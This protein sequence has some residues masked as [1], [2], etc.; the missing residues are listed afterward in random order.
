MGTRVSVETFTSTSD[1][2]GHRYYASFDPYPHRQ[3][4]S[5]LAYLGILNGSG[6]LRRKKCVV[7]AFRHGSATREDWTVEIDKSIL[8]KEIADSYNRVIGGTE[9][10]ITVSIP[11]LAEIDEPS[12]CTCINEVLGKEGRIIRETEYVS[13]ELYLRGPF[14]DFEFGMADPLD[15]ITPEAFAH[16]SWYYS[17]GKHL[18]TNIQG[19]KSASV[20]YITGPVVHSEDASHGLTD[21]GLDG[22]K[23]FFRYHRCNRICEKWPR[24]GD[25]VEIRD[26]GNL[27]GSIERVMPS[28]HAIYADSSMILSMPLPPYDNLYS[29]DW[30]HY[31]MSQGV[32]NPW[33][34]SNT[35]G[36]SHF[37]SVYMQHMAYPPSLYDRSSIPYPIYYHPSPSQT[38]PPPYFSAIC[39]RNESHMRSSV[40]SKASDRELLLDPND[41][42]DEQVVEESS[43]TYL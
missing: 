15:L 42:A 32:E 1:K 11:I 31:I 8:V 36:M 13:L 25:G 35:M 26:A 41:F 19:V 37:W 24:L 39:N 28:A 22:I 9:Y 3:G 5:K 20:Y 27:I 18:V 38:Y 17:Q 34:P 30:H 14:E 40:C 7:K 6:P 21:K 16:Y 33:F 4:K 23:T 43:M 10:K 12:N 29:K 2:D